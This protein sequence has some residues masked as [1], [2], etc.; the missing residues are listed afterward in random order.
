MEYG[1]ND[2]VL[3]KIR[4]VLG[5]FPGIEEA[6]IYGSR[7]VGTHKLGSDIDITLKA[8]LSFDEMIQL[9]KELDDLMLPYTFDLSIYHK[10][11]NK[12][13]VEHID[14]VGKQFYTKETIENN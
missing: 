1:L 5:S 2:N 3:Q 13:L 8:D 4:K 11:S 7:A 10:L 6:I 9:E 14:R 12:N